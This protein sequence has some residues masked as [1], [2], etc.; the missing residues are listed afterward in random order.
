MTLKNKL[1]ACMQSR[2]ALL[3]VNFYNFETLKGLL[4]AARV[5]GR[6]LILQLSQSSIE[7]MGLKPA[8]AMARVML[9]EYE[10]EGWI[11]LDHGSS[12]DI[13]KS[14]LDA[15]FD[16]VMIDASEKSFE[17]NVRITQQAVK[18]AVA[19]HANVEAEL[20]YVAK[21]G[22]DQQAEPTPAADAK[23]FAE[24]TGIDALAIAIGNAHGFYKQT[25]KLNLER[26]KEIRAVTSCALVLHGS[27]GIPDNQLREAIRAGISKINLATETKNCFMKKLQSLLADTDEID[28]RKI[29]PKAIQ[30]VQKL[31][32]RKL[33]VINS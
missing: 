24:L 1:A 17:E 7:Y 8:V 20:G 22:Q 19:Y 6:P 12:L 21:L 23:R 16:S 29:F 26:L 5:T 9:N 14:C 28:L 25:P 33:E 32:T 15:G 31:I 18:M 4:L 3:A 30:E 11:H 10:V 13:V 27:S 2:S